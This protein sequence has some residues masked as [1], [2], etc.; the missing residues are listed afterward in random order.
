MRFSPSD[1]EKAE[2]LSCVE[3]IRYHLDKLDE[4]G[5]QWYTKQESYQKFTGT[6]VRHKIVVVEDFYGDVLEVIE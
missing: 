4:L 2:A 3:E 1:E 5:Y 6:A